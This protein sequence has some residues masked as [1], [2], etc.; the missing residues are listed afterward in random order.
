[1]GTDRSVSTEDDFTTETPPRHSAGQPNVKPKPTGCQASSPTRQSRANPFQSHANS[2]PIQGQSL[3]NQPIQCQ[4][5]TNPQIRLP[6][7]IGANLRPIRPHMTNILSIF[8]SKANPGLIRPSTN[9]RS[10]PDQ[11]IIGQSPHP[12]TIR[13][14]INL[15]IP[16]RS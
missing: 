13:Q 4:S 11:S 15:P 8:Q 1:M 14:S 5:T 3:T 6:S 10:I 12:A 2:V 7:T 16:A 9:P